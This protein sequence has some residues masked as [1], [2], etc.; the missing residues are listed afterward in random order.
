MIR[1]GVNRKRPFEGESFG[2]IDEL[3]FPAIPQNRLTDESIILEGRIEDHQVR[4]FFVNGGSSSEIMYGHFFRNLSVN[5]RSMLRRCRASLIGRNKIVLME[6]AIVKCHSP[7][8]VIIGRIRMRSLGAIAERVQGSWKEMQWRQREE[9]MSRIREQAILR[10][11]SSS[12]HGPYQV[13]YKRRPMT[14]D[15]R[16]ALKERVFHWMK[17]GTI[18][19]VQHPEWVANAMPV[20][21]ANGAWKVQVDYSSLNKVCAK[22][23]YPFPE[24]GEGLVS[25]MEYPYKCFL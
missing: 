10:T 5:I 24:E 4:R 22:D 11:K 20:K 19:K 16:Q 18:R 17:E 14:P 13:V 25:L 1:G 7:Y 21:L 2:L 9:K 12:G 8:K 23:M 6:F 15:G 3:T